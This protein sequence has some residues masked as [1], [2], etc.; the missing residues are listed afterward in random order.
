MSA[1]KKIFE[2]NHGGK[3]RLREISETV[4][5]NCCFAR[6]SDLSL[7]VIWVLMNV[8]QVNKHDR[9]LHQKAHAESVLKLFSNCQPNN[10]ARL[11]STVSSNIRHIHH[12]QAKRR[13]DQLACLLLVLQELHHVHHRQVQHRQD[14]LVCLLQRGLHHVHPC[15][16]QDCHKEAFPFIDQP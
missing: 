14:R 5:C 9:M 3:T 12:C 16:A 1:T 10:V 15:Q 11:A 6:G 4:S 13:Q 8:L 2:L 7:H